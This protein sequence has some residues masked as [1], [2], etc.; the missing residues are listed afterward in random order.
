MAAENAEAETSAQLL[1]A[2]KVL[3]G[4]SPYITVEQLQKDL[5]PELAA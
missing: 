1:E 5:S 2:F 3:A 4:D